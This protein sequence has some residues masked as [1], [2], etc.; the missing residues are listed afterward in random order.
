MVI[1]IRGLVITP[2][3]FEQ[4]EQLL[5][6]ISEETLGHYRFSAAWNTVH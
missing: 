4:I 1:T 5:S 2:E 6:E 3:A